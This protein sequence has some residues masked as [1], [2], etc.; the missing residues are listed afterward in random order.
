MVGKLGQGMY[1]QGSDKTHRPDTPTGRPRDMAPYREGASCLYCKVN[2][3][4]GIMSWDHVNLVQNNKC[5]LP[6]GD[7]ALG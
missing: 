3:A 7:S 5:P 4:T 2:I 6:V 1:W